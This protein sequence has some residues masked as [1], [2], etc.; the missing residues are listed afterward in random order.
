MGA[1]ICCQS[2]EVLAIFAEVAR[3]GV[4]GVLEGWR[5]LGDGV[6]VSGTSRWSGTRVLKRIGEVVCR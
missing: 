6:G 4:Y 1:T 5:R 3:G 2:F